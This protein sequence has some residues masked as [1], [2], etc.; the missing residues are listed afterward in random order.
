M[1]RTSVGAADA[2]VGRGMVTRRV[3][4]RSTKLTTT[5]TPS[6]MVIWRQAWARGM[7][8]R[9]PTSRVGF[10]FRTS[11][12]ASTRWWSPFHW[13]KGGARRS[14]SQAQTKTSSGR[15]KPPPEP[16]SI[17]ARLK[18]LSREYGWAAVGVYMG[19]SVL[20]FPFCFL[21]VRIVGTERIGEDTLDAVGIVRFGGTFG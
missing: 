5:A 18:K 21:L 3:I 8:K 12:S 4:A 13:S 16:T 19:L 14:S 2:L 9:T 17:S 7:S 11:P 6:S 15:I 20:D 10:Q 1:L